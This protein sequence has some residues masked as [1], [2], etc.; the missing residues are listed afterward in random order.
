M[1][2]ALE[3]HYFSYSFW[4]VYPCSHQEKKIKLQH[5]RSI[6]VMSKAPLNI[7]KLW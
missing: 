5:A 4:I 2:I 6:S 7:L 1:M 3:L